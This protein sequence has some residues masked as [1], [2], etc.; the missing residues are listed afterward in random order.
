MS[1]LKTTEFEM[2]DLFELDSRSCLHSRQGWISKKSKSRRHPKIRIQRGRIIR[3]TGF[4]FYISRGQ[5]HDRAG[6]KQ[7]TPWRSIT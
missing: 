6:E 4:L 1:P 3:K 2:F 5:G 7:T